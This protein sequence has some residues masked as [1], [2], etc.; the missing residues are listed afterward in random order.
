M[1]I[2]VVETEQE[3]TL[4]FCMRRTEGESLWEEKDGGDHYITV[5]ANQKVVKAT[6][7][8]GEGVTSVQDYNIGFERKAAEDTISFYYRNDMAMLDDSLAELDGTVSVVVENESYEMTYNAETERYEY[9]YQNCETGEYEYYYTVNGETVLDYFNENQNGN[10]TANVLTYKK[11]SDVSI[12]ASSYY[13]TMD[14]NDNNVICVDYNEEVLS[15]DEISRITVDLSELGLGDM[16]IEPS[17]M[18]VT[19]TVANTVSA[20]KKKL[21]VSITDIYGNIYTTEV[22]V[23]VVE[24]D[25]IFNWEEAV[26]YMALTDRFYDGN[27]DNNDGV[28][29]EGTLSYHGGDFAG[30]EEKLD[31]LQSL[32]INTVWITPIVQNSDMIYETEDGPYE[33]TGFHGYWASDFTA[34]SPHLGTEEALKSLIDALHER[35]MKLMVDIVINHAGY[36]T[37]SYFNSLLDGTNMI[38]SA[39]ETVTG[40]DIYASLSGLPDFLTENKDVADQLIQWQ[41]DWI[42]KF[43]IDYYRVDTVK[44]VESVVWAKFKNELAKVDQDFK[45]IGEYYGAGYAN[46]A[47]YLNSGTMDSLLDFDF[48]D[49]L[50][51][52][53]GGDIETAE[54]FLTG[55]N[56]SLSNTATLGSFLSSHDE[57]I[58]VDS[59]INTGRTEEEALALAKV[60][61]SVQLTA[62]GQIVIY[63]GEEIGQHGLSSD[64]PIQSNRADFNWNAAETQTGDENSMLAHYQKL[65]AIR[66]EHKELL[67]GADRTNIV[68]SNEDGYD[69][70]KRTINNESMY[71]ALNITASETEVTFPVDQK[72]GSEL[73]DLYSGKSYVVSDTQEVTITIPAA[74]DGGTVIFYV[75]GGGNNSKILI[76]AGAIAAAIVVV[77]GIIVVKKKV[78]H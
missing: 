26:I 30:L 58:F 33:S 12:T 71:V 55:R 41:V 67:A 39:A 47:G 15:E 66:A 34:L 5:P 60:A 27:K 75:N 42:R 2:P 40:D 65:L 24:S 52:F 61:A 3:M 22:Q 32:G 77:A 45:L 9:D 23:T 38:R 28:N 59:L 57:D 21:P 25:D 43:D 53:V 44:H 62:K 50:G 31:Y 64:Y 16:N 56:V 17:L 7:T 13:D 68:F 36:G 46:T 74:A 49:Q 73:T 48:N 72:A 78:T 1:I 19:I 54:N 37:E 63:Y 20:G 51:T 35:D 10:G 4:S 18:E 6:F 76:F 69:V 14:Y 29:L 8:Q 70:F 11:I